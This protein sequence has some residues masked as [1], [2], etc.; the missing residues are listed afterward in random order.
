MSH[1]TEKTS[2]R[3]WF[4]ILII[5]KK[6]IYFSCS[7]FV[8]TFLFR[9]WF[10]IFLMNEQYVYKCRHDVNTFPWSWLNWF[11]GCYSL[12]RK[13][14]QLQSDFCMRANVCCRSSFIYFYFFFVR[15]SLL[16][17]LFFDDHHNLKREILN[18][19]FS[20]NRFTPEW[21]FHHQKVVIVYK[22]IAIRLSHNIANFHYVTVRCDCVLAASKL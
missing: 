8:F 20:L 1:V 4:K 14:N 21:F 18:F 19:M 17:Q 13:S 5:K 10:S 6:S 2:M 12:V 7:Y 16:L 11:Q 22:I 9:I 3:H 15:V